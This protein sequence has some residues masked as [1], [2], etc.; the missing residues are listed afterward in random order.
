MEQ[1]AISKVRYVNFFLV[2]TAC[3]T[4]YHQYWQKRSI[5]N[6][7]AAAVATESNENC[8]RFRLL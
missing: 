4:K 1:Y 2:P 5:I 7:S 6:L 3:V 8:Q